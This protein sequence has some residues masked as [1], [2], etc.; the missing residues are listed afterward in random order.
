MKNSA[1]SFLYG[2][3]FISFLAIGLTSYFGVQFPQT[4][5]K[6]A[7]VKC[8]D[9]RGIEKVKKYFFVVGI[10]CKNGATF[11]IPIKTK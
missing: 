4:W 10:E 6:D 1:D 7:E 5:F 8:A 3:L 9:N 11:E 2:M